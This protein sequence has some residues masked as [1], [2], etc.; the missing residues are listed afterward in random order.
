MAKISMFKPYVNE[1]AIERV[2]QTLRSGWIGEGPAVKEFER[3]IGARVGNPHAVAVNSGTSALHLALLVAGVR[4]G[5]EVITTAQTMLAST[6]AILAVGAKP[7]YADIQYLTGN[8]EPS[9]VAAHVTERTRAVLGVDWGGYPCD[10]DELH[11]VVKDRPIAVIEDAAHALGARYRGRPIGSVCRY[12]CFSFQAIKHLTTVDGG[13]LT[14][15]TP[16]ERQRAAR[17]RWFGLDRDLRQPSVLGEPIWNVK[18]LGFKYHMNDVAASI[19]LG[20]LEDAEVNL[21]RRRDI[22]ARYR[23]ELARVPGLTLWERRSD[24]ES[25]D[26]LFSIHVERREDFCRALAARGVETSV[27]HLRID[28]ND[29]CGGE[30]PDLPVLRRFTDTHVSLPLHP[31]LT[32]DDISTVIAAVRKGWP[33]PRHRRSICSSRSCPGPPSSE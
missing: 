32:N 30:R 26:W 20:N 28:R 13:M 18:E 25:A 2:V 1:K 8:L 31:L 14:V 27:V 15:S 12:T 21:R 9:S 24:R 17:L 5:D 22:S 6:Q 19:G 3:E 11:A 16:E 7:V 10:W 29:L 33:C 4:A 23:E